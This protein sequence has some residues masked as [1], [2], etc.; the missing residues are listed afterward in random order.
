MKVMVD[1]SIEYR[2]QLFPYAAEINSHGE[3]FNTRPQLET[4]NEKNNNFGPFI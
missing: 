4:K 1:L 3:I 2:H